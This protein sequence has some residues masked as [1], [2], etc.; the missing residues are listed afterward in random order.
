MESPWGVP[1]KG[2]A[3]PAIADI[4]L[5][6]IT[7]YFIDDDTTKPTIDQIRQVGA[8]WVFNGFAAERLDVGGDMFLGQATARQGCRADNFD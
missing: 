5:K 7:L 1:S 4:R 3:E 2:D 8:G 6:R